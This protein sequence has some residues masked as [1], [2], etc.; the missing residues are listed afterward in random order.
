MSEKEYTTLDAYTAG[1]LSL[2]GFQ[3]RF[4][5][6]NSKVVF[7]FQDSTEIQHALLELESGALVDAL[8]LIRTVKYLRSQIYRLRREK[9]KCDGNV[10]VPIP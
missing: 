3:P 2:R 7:L 8:R 1:W 6:Q 4:I 10:K 5:V 9:E